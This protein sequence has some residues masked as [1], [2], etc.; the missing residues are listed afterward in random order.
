MR[1]ARHC[2]LAGSD[3]QR[4]QMALAAVLAIDSRGPV[5]ADVAQATTGRVALAD[6]AHGDFL[7]TRR[8]PSP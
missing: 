1:K 2:D 5:L 4:L 3:A 7:I 8:P 6:G